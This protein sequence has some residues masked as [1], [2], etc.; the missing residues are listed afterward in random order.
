M[1]NHLN[2]VGVL[3]YC[4]GGDSPHPPSR[5]SSVSDAR[6][7]PPFSWL[8]RSFL[9]SL[10]Q[11]DGSLLRLLSKFRDETF[12]ETNAVMNDNRQSRRELR[13]APRK[14]LGCEH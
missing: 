9:L 14:E 7:I 1:H 12:S 11:V 4:P 5:L 10:P 6:R 8:V 3:H 2:G 13:K